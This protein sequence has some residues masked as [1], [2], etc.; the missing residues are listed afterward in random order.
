MPDQIL[1]KYFIS[2]LVWYSN[3]HFC[4]IYLFIYLRYFSINRLLFVPFFGKV[5]RAFCLWLVCLCVC[6]GVDVFWLGCMPVGLYAEM[7]LAG[8]VGHFFETLNGEC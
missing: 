6:V 4:F 3:L 8:S 7:W 2:Y 5:G 1:I